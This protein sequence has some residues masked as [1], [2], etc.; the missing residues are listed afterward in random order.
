LL[1][2]YFTQRADTVTG[3]VSW[4]LPPAESVTTTFN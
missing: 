1:S 3:I 4:A 2:F